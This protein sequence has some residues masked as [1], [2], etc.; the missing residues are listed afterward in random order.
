VDAT[1]PALRIVRE[2]AVTLEALREVADVE[3]RQVAPEDDPSGAPAG[4]AE[5][6]E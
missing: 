3:G 5:D 4:A 2:G 6:N 1:G